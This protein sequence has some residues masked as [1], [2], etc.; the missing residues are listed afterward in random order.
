MKKN[1]LL[2]LLILLI[3]LTFAGLIFLFK[4]HAPADPTLKTL[5]IDGRKLFVELADTDAKRARG[6]SGRDKL[7]QNEG[8]LFIFPT[9]GFYRFWMKEMKFPL[10]FVWINDDKIVDLTENVSPPKT[11]NE[12]LSTFTAKNPFNKVLEIN[13]GV[14]KSLDIKIGDQILL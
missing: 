5:S 12:I 6:L 10:D 7:A 3:F 11:P 1:F 4:P 9:L 8:M 14:V 2:A 13:A